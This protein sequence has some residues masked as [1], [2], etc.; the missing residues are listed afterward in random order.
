MKSLSCKMC[1]NPI[2]KSINCQFLYTKLPLRLQ[3]FKFF[4]LLYYSIFINDHSKLDHTHAETAMF[5]RAIFVLQPLYSNT[6]SIQT[7]LP[8]TSLYRPNFHIPLYID[9]S[10]TY[11][12]IQT[13]LPHT[14][15]YRPLFHILLY[16]DQSSTYLSIQTTLP[17]T[18]LYRP[19]FHI[20]L[21]T[22]QS[23]TYLS[24]QTTLPHTSLYR[25]LF[26]IPLYTDQ[27]ST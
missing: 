6:L 14:S 24:I 16:T 22:D 23:S 1:F 27:S 12:S 9:Q 26:H 3:G 10:S 18:S 17:H 2:K 4:S 15:L 8:H 7:N 5:Q 25:P 19:I 21:Y 20:P 13:T 11:L